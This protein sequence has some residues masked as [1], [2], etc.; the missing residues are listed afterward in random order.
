[1]T[2]RGVASLPLFGSDADRLKFLSL[3]AFY[4]RKH[5]VVIHV[6][7][8]MGNHFHL[9]LEDPR[10]NL[11]RFMKGV[12][13]SY[14]RY[15]NDVRGQRGAGHV[16]KGRFWSQSISEVANY[17]L[18]AS[19]ILL[20]PLRCTPSLAERAELYPWSSA[21]LHC[22]TLESSSYFR[23][24]VERAG[25]VEVVLGKWP[26][27]SRAEYG[28]RWREQLES[29]FA[30]GWI[31]PAAARCGRS[32]GQMR[33]LLRERAGMPQPDEL[34][35]D[36]QASEVPEVA[37]NRAGRNR[38]QARTTI[39]RLVNEI[40]RATRRF[41]GERLGSVGE[42]LLAACADLLPEVFERAREITAYLLWR[43]TDGR[44]AEIARLI[45]SPPDFVARAIEEVRHLKRTS[46]AWATLL[47]RLE[48][49]LHFRLSSAPWRS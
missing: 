15:F 46:K 43:Y 14:A 40:P 2:S 21:P 23:S 31:S 41:K 36:G 28:E 38:R 20:N 34:L 3:L 4:A 37:K 30:D 29:L 18:V 49:T 6:F 1:M 45:K 47:W 8:L 26:R 24:L 9:L 32:P 12:K 5:K 7:C 10:G 25:G 33:R 19:Y 17:D 27:P 48:W 39:A 13:Q 16:Y 35:H 22:S 44:T 11:S 42:R